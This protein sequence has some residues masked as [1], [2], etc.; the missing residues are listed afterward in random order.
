M[1]FS[2]WRPF[3]WD[4]NILIVNI[5]LYYNVNITRDIFNSPSHAKDYAF[6]ISVLTT[7]AIPLTDMTPHE[8]FN[9]ST[10]KSQTTYIWELEMIMMIMIMIKAFKKV[11]HVNAS[12]AKC[13]PADTWRNNNIIITS[14]WRHNVVWRNND[15]V[16]TSCVFWALLTPYHV[17]SRYM[18]HWRF[19]D[20]STRI[21][22]DNKKSSRSQEWDEKNNYIMFN[23]H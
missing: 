4:L 1:S 2:K 20:G 3:C 15:V 16:I 12:S 14:K 13:Q 22:C 11:Y 10:W 17:K 23:L 5:L 18:P 19:R 21:H 7:Y 9:V 6:F 8:S